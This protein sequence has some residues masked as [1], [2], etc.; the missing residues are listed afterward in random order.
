MHFHSQAVGCCP[1]HQLGFSLCHLC[2]VCGSY[3]AYF[4]RLSCQ[5]RHQAAFTE[6][7]SAQTFH[8][9]HEVTILSISLYVSG[10]GAGPLL[11]GPLSEVYGAPS[12]SLPDACDRLYCVKAEI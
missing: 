10:L 7:G 6:A 9:S 2:I 11:V 8:V 4:S 5:W 12:V 3:F 1:Y